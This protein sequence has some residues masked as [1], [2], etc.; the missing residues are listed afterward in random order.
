MNP[1]SHALQVAARVWLPE[2]GCQHLHTSGISDAEAH[3]L[4]EHFA[5]QTPPLSD[6]RTSWEP[7]SWRTYPTVYV[8][9]QRRPDPNSPHRNVTNLWILLDPRRRLSDANVRRIAE[10]SVTPNADSNFDSVI[11]DWIDVAIS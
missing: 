2:K 11:R 8:I 3:A 5:G 1:T 10:T 7:H 6:E 4:I 9:P